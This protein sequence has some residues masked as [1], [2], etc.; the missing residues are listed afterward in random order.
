[1]ESVN[2]E[3]HYCVVQ[4]D[5]GVVDFATKAFQLSLPSEPTAAKRW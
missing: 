4:R 2:F 1:L 5:K 3:L